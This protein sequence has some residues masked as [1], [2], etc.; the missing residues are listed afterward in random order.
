MIDHTTE[1]YCI[2]DDLLKASAHTEDTRRVMS[3]AEVLTTTLVAAQFFGSNLEHARCFLQETAL[4]PQMFSKSRLNCRLH[5]IADLAYTLFHQLGEV[6]KESGLSNKYLLD[7]FPVA[8]CD[9]IRISRS[10][11]V[12][13]EQF[14]G[15]SAR[16]G[17]TS[18]A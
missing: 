14:R 5:A 9:N 10:Q 4:M 13:G 8:V 15:A 2:I 7:S 18:T 1:L 12:R 6:L 17:A 3:D 11:L 16:K